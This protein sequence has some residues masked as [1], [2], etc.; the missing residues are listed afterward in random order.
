MIATHD[1][2]VLLFPTLYGDPTVTENGVVNSNFI[3]QEKEYPITKDVKVMLYSYI[4]VVVVMLLF[5][6]KCFQFHKKK[7]QETVAEKIGCFKRSRCSK[8]AQH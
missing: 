1:F 5:A 4:I 2:M 7:P 8:Q 6:L 3:F